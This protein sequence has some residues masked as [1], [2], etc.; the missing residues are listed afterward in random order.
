MI[1]KVTYKEEPTLFDDIVEFSI[2]ENMDHRRGS[3]F[4]RDEIIE[5]IEE[6]SKHFPDIKDFEKYIG[7]WRTNNVIWSEDDGFDTDYTS[8]IRVKQKE[9]LTYEWEEVN[10]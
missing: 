1:N 9:V 10:E 4:Y 2:E 3:S 8:L 7:T 5:F 6:D